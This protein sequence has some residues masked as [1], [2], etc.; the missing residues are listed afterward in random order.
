MVDPSCGAMRFEF[1]IRAMYQPSPL[2]DPSAS[3]G[4]TNG[5]SAKQQE[6]HNINTGDGERPFFV[7]FVVEEIISLCLGACRTRPC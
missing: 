3:L 2:R 4:M 7:P 1:G 5:E 6:S